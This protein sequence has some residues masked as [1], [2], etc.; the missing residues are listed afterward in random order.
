MK[1]G[2]LLLH[3]EQFCL[4][5]EVHVLTSFPQRLVGLLTQRGLPRGHAYWF[6]SCSAVHSWG[7]HFALDII[8]LD[9]QQ[10]IVEIRR[11][12]QPSSVLR[13]KG[14]SSIIECEAGYPYPLE[15]MCGRRVT[16]EERE[17][18]YEDAI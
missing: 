6:P 17:V 3:P 4:W 11:N 7:M 14:V 10:R 18:G 15:S 9:R 8:G 1:Y 2:R 13:L 5:H 16:F 12:V